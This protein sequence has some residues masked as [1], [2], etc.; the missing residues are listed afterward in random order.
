MTELKKL[1][2]FTPGVNTR[3]DDFDLLLPDFRSRYLRLAYNVDIRGSGKLRRRQGFTLKLAGADCHSLWPAPGGTGVY[4]VDGNTLYFAQQTAASAWTK[5]AVRTNVT[6]GALLT[7]ADMAGQLAYSDGTYV[8]LLSGSTDTPLNLPNVASVGVMSAG[9][10]GGLLTGL[11][12]ASWCYVG[13][14][15]QL[16]PATLSQQVSVPAS[17]T[18]TL[19]GL[20]AA[21]PSGV[22]ALNIYLTPPDGDQLFLAIQLPAPTTTYTFTAP[23]QQGHLCQTTLLQPLPGGSILRYLNG[24]TMSASGTLITYSEPYST[25][26]SPM[27]GYIPLPDPVTL[28]EPCHRGWYLGT[29]S[30]IWWLPADFTTAE[31]ESKQTFGA[32]PGTGAQLPEKNSVCFMTRRGLAMGDD[33]GQITLLQDDLVATQKART[34]V[35][36]FRRIDGMKQVVASLFGAE[37]AVASAQSYMN[38]EVIRGSAK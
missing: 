13:P 16:G 20:P 36:G 31:L 22:A 24:R 32:I 28:M 17:G 35:T 14:T 1:G 37:P 3:V 2:P 27:R 33:S 23:P 34:G 19:T 15:G 7:Y 18:I 29:R 26:Y 4:F 12:Q 21:F 6:P 10:G 11:Y 8:G 38:A 9:T 25:L 5:T 30:Q